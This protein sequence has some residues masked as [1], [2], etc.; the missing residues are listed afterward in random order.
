MKWI[1][2][3]IEGPI[4]IYKGESKVGGGGGGGGGPRLYIN[5][6]QEWVKNR[7]LVL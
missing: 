3:S 4:I 5:R 2:K 6:Q 1:G 7:I